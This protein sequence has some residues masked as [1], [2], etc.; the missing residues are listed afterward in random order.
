MNNQ[1]KF[2]AFIVETFKRFGVKSPRFFQ[3]FQTIGII[4]T[5]IGFIPD[6]LQWLDITPGPIYS[7]YIS[8]AVKVAGG[9]MWLMAKLPVQNPERIIERTDKLPFTEKTTA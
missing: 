9:V 4:A 2:S 6:A 3:V 7:K 8:L 5:G 1:S